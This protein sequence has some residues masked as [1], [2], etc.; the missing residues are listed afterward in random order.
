FTPPG[1]AIAKSGLVAPEFQAVDALTVASYANLMATVIEKPGWPGGDVTTTYANEIAALAPASATAPDNDQALIDRIN[2]L[3]FGG[4]MS[5]TLS[6]RLTRV[7][8]STVSTAK[9]PTAAQLATVRMNKVQSALIIAL[10]APE[11][12]VQR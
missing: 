9:A 8:S 12:V 5:S 3:Y 1:S 7:L 10:T 2:L 11:Y 4:S 6:S